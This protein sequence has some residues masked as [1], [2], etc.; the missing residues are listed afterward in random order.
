MEKGT[1]FLKSQVN[2][3]VM[4]H[5]MFL[6]NLIDHEKQAGDE[7]F[8]AL[9]SG[10]VSKAEEHQ[11][12]LEDYQR[13]IGAEAG[14]AKKAIARRSALRAT[15]LTCPAPATSFVSSATS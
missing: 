7:R 14:L 8:R 9:C 5:R 13:E 2:N 15:W 11:R 12:M 10:F 4:Q 6:Q 1:D 3:A